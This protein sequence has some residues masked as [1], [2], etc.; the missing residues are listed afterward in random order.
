MIDE[1]VIEL[2]VIERLFVRHNDLRHCVGFH[3]Y[4][5]LSL[6]SRDRQLLDLINIRDDVADDVQNIL[7]VPPS[8][9]RP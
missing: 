5:N 9:I 3:W 7:A 1:I 8:N 2:G 6:F 4:L